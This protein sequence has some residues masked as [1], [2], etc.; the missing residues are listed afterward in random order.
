MAA[1]Q[2]G[3]DALL[4]HAAGYKGLRIGMVTNDAAT[5]SSGILSRV[6]LLQAGFNITQL[7][8]PEHG[9]AR[10][11]EDGAP[12]P[13][14]IDA[15]TGLPIVSLYGNQLAPNAT[16]LA[17]IDTVVFD[18]PDIG[19][20]FYT[21]LWTMTH[22]M[23]ACAAH[24]KPLVVVDRPNPTGAQLHKAEGPWLNEL[25]CS[26][27]IGRWNIPLRHCCTLGELAQYFA[28]DRLPRLQLSVVPVTGYQ[29]HY[30]AM[31]HFPFVPTSPAMQTLQAALLYPGTGLW[32][33]VNLN[34]GRGTAAPF[35]LCGAPWLNNQALA[36]QLQLP[37]LLVRPHDFTAAVGPYAGEQ[38]RGLL[39]QVT[40]ADAFYPVR[41]GLKLLRAIAQIHPHQ[42]IERAYPTAANPSGQ[43]HL[44]RLLGQPGSFA[45]LLQGDDFVI[46]V[47]AEWEGMMGE[48]LLY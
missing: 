44:D 6:A 2:F 39:L 35:A 1:V 17:D 29:R 28:A 37:G 47:A 41:S 3:I 32:E 8:A 24:G 18:I 27:F 45:R 16:D 19:C 4:P 48:W 43:G 34:E 5:T 38:C 15:L 30:T 9:I 11:G 36:E 10:A 20:R 31:A 12:Q 7:F 13:N 23:E 14:G 25:A 33:G 46:D 26:S 22:V 21:Y 40:D 42:L